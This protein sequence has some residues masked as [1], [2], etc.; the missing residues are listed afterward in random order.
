MCVHFLF[1]NKLVFILFKFKI[2]A[3]KRVKKF[4]KL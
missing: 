4:F 1:K 2:Y 3:L